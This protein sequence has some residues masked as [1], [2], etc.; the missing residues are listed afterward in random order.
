[1]LGWWGY[2]RLLEQ[3]MSKAMRR[4]RRLTARIP[5]RVS[6][7]NQWTFETVT[8]DVSVSGMFLTAP[9]FPTHISRVV[10]ECILPDR[11]DSVVMRARVA[12]RTE[13]GIGIELMGGC[14][15]GDVERWSRFINM[16]QAHD[17]ASSWSREGQTTDVFIEHAL[18]FD[19]IEEI[20][21]FQQ[22]DLYMGGFFLR[23]RAPLSVG[24]RI[25]LTIVHPIDGSR[26]VIPVTVTRRVLSEEMGV[27]V[28]FPNDL[29]RLGKKLEVFIERGV[30]E[31]SL[32]ELTDPS[33]LFIRDEVTT[34]HVRAPR[35]M[36][37]R[38]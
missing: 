11:L 6:T 3:I 37:G 8:G 14:M 7:A 32:D 21:E 22:I 15:E 12:R 18:R 9:N 30:P 33:A 29:D 34:P 35:E 23:T 16:T 4:H 25:K 20:D 38:F 2:S 10:V 19:S 28:A 24:D 1:M 36:A 5:V 26:F 17:A 27:C 13:D 31:L